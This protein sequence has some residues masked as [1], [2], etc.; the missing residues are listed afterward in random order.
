MLTSRMA[1]DIPRVSYFGVFDG[2]GGAAMSGEASK[3]LPKTIVTSLR[4]RWNGVVASTG[5]S[6]AAASTP[7]QEVRFYDPDSLR[8]IL[9]RA[10]LETDAELK[11][12]V[13]TLP[14]GCVGGGECIVSHEHGRAGE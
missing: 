10:F 12:C 5:G 8:T 7:E 1:D 4:E 14:L 3:E 11:R 13:V 9:R 6:A 2:H